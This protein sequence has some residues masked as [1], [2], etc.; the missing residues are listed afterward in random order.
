MAKI[1]VMVNGLGRDGEGK[2]AQIIAGGIIDSRDYELIPFSLTGPDR[3]KRTAVFPPSKKSEKM[4]DV[5]LIPP[6]YHNSALSK[7]TD[8]FDSPYII[9]FCKGEGVANTNAKLYIANNIPF[10]M[11]STGADYDLIKKLSAEADNPCVAYPNM[12]VR[13]V[14]WMA[15]LQ[16]MAENFSGAFK[17]AKIEL[18][19]SHQAD[20]R[21]TSGTMKKTLEALAKLSSSELTEGNI[22]KIRDPAVQ[23]KLVGVPENWTGW[24]AY[25]LFRIFNDHSGNRDSEE[26][27]FKRHGGECYRQGAMKALDFLVSC[28]YT[29]PFN[30][31]IDVITIS[32]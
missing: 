30:T 7:L 26:L 31:M 28:K 21:D 13:I 15:G 1:K 22:T 12:D 3:P 20:K 16:Y 29:K 2:M 19:E 23:A 32:K 9:D 10:V 14:T 24:H 27:T 4:A 17:G 11:G 6:E 5:E 18:W 25:H 8:T